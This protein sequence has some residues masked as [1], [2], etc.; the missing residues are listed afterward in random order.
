MQR[1]LEAPLRPGAGVIDFDGHLI[2][3]FGLK[4]RTGD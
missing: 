1:G 3:F 2:L 4:M